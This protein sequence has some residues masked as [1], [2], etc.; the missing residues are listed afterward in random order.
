MKKLI[1]LSFLIL[2]TG[3]EKKYEHVSVAKEFQLENEAQNALVERFKT[4]WEHFS[5]KD[6]NQSYPL[7]LTYKRYLHDQAW[8]NK[9]NAANRANYTITLLSLKE[10]SKDIVDVRAQF[11]YK[12]TSYKFSDRWYNVNGTWEHN[13]QTSILPQVN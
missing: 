6:F 4:Y 13:M 1:F 3:C 9:F 7:E 8:Y 12:E 10:K 5:A 11:S 2:M